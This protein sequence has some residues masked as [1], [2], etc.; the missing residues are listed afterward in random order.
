[1]LYYKG[2]FSLSCVLLPQN[3]PGQPPLALTFFVLAP[4][5]IQIKHWS[6][7]IIKNVKESYSCDFEGNC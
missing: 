1:M 6:E 7:D 5:N 2:D 3:S 4:P